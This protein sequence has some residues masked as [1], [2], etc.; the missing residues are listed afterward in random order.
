[1]ADQ[2]REDF[3][4]RHLP[5]SRNGGSILGIEEYQTALAGSLVEVQFGLD[6][7]YGQGLS[8]HPF[9]IYI[10]EHGKKE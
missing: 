3:E 7:V 10:I 2:V 4:V 9:R 1:M 6:N 8:A 5:I